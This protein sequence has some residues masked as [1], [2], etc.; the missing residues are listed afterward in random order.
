MYFFTV[1]WARQNCGKFS[2]F[3]LK[4]FLS[5][6]CICPY[7]P[8]CL[9]FTVLFL[10]MEIVPDPFQVKKPL[11][12]LLIRHVVVRLFPVMRVSKWDVYVCNTGTFS[13]DGMRIFAACAFP[14]GGS[15]IQ[16]ELINHLF[17]LPNKRGSLSMEICTA[18]WKSTIRS[19]KGHK[20]S[21]A[22][23]LVYLFVLHQG[24]CN[25]GSLSVL[26]H[27]L[28]FMASDGTW[29]RSRFYNYTVNSRWLNGN[30]FFM[31]QNDPFVS[32][33]TL[34][35]PAANLLLGYQI[36]AS[37]NADSSSGIQLECRLLFTG[38]TRP[39]MLSL[40]IWCLH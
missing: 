2:E 40:V 21:K 30:D 36:Q 20:D 10:V 4:T 37:Y 39:P 18:D 13:C 38:F 3:S 31:C 25:F 29:S 7:K 16:V 8:P 12:G 27:C 15:Y 14:A 23:R 24:T 1:F 11:N 19:W 35:L 9:D 26:L 5:L 6:I 33:F 17:I 28:C 32:H 22:E 34:L